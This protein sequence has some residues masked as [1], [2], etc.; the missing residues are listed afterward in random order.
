MFRQNVVEQNQFSR[1]FNLFYRLSLVG[2]TG[3]AQARLYNVV[4]NFRL[5]RNTVAFLQE[6]KTVRT[7]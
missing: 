1:A 2:K 3:R 5:C 7:G 4:A 6:E